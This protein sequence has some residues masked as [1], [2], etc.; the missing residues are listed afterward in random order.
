MYIHS[1]HIRNIGCLGTEESPLELDLTHEDG[2]CA[3]WTVIAGPN[4]TGK[5]TLLRAIA[6]ATTGRDEVQSLLESA[7]AFISDS[8]STGQINIEVDLSNDDLVGST[9]LPLGEQHRRK[10]C[11]FGLDWRRDPQSEAP[12]LV[13]ERS[14]VTHADQPEKSG[15]SHMDRTPDWFVAGYGAN[16][17]MARG[18]VDGQRLTDSSRPAVAQLASLFREDAVFS[19]TT[20]WLERQ[21]LLRLE[22]KNGSRELLTR[23][24]GLLN[25]GLLPGQ[26]QLVDVDSE[27]IWARHNGQKLPVRR[28]GDGYQTMTGTVLDIIRHLHRARGGLKLRQLEARWVVDNEGVVLIDEMELHLHPSWQQ[29]AGFWFKEHFPNIQFIVTTH[30][31]FVCQAADPGG[32]IRLAGAAENG[33]ALKLTGSAF[34]A[35]VHGTVDDAVLSDLF[36]LEDLRSPIAEKLLDEVACLESTVIDGTATPEEITRYRELKEKLPPSA[37]I[38]K[39]LKRL[40]S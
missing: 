23:I 7:A 35:V 33:G 28:L 2:R 13:M 36:G 16:R 12:L 10:Q 4:G 30:S 6:L 3:G 11:V 17:R 18:S 5:T 19:E 32:L 29:R 25:D 40:E 8:S 31:P 39:A 15:T 26:V 27:G 1:V 22:N 24:F 21:H 37:D 14:S 34:H 20:Q 9:T 38:V